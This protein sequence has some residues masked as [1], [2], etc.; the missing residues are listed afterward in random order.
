MCGPSLPGAVLNQTEV[1]CPTKDEKIGLFRT[2][3]WVT[4]EQ[5]VIAA[6][7]TT[8]KGW[9]DWAVCLEVHTST[10]TTV[11]WRD[12]FLWR[13]LLRKGRHNTRRCFLKYLENSGRQISTTRSLSHE[14]GHC[15][16]LDHGLVSAQSG[17][18]FCWTCLSLRDQHPTPGWLFLRL[19]I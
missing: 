4:P 15:G 13:S 19:G 11:K 17:I 2:R 9:A 5:S 6:A 14:K 7:G 8:P 12:G 3:E 10:N 16:W 1:C 18:C